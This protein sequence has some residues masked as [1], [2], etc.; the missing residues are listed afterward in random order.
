MR[1]TRKINSAKALSSKYFA[2]FRGETE[3]SVIHLS[4]GKD[5]PVFAIAL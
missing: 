1:V 5:Y 2:I 4:I 3:H